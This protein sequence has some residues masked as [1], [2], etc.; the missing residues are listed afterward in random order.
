MSCSKLI[1]SLQSIT[2]NASTP[3]AARIKTIA[4]ILNKGIDDFLCGKLKMGVEAFEV[5][6]LSVISDAGLMESRLYDV[7]KVAVHPDNREEEMAVVADIQ[8]LLDRMV[9]DGFNPKRWQA[10]A[11]TIP[12][13]PEGDRWRAENVKLVNESD[14]YL[15]P[16]RAGGLEIVTARGSHG[17]CALRC[18]M[19]GAKA[20]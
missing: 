17:T 1:S 6:V 10:L 4:P 8:D 15:P 13:G 2:F 20:L 11:C 18:A 14:G 3:R 5:E 7:S 19:F 16:V 12:E 9:E